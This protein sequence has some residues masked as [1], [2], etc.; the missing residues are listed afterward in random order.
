MVLAVILS[1]VSVG[2]IV[3]RAAGG[4]PLYLAAVL[5]LALL[6][7]VLV[8][9]RWRLLARSLDLIVPVGVAVRAQFVAMFG[10]QVLPSA[11]G[12]DVLRGWAVT[13]HAGDVSRVVASL[14]ADRLVALFAACLLALPSLG[15]LVGP[16]VLAGWVG[17][18]WVARLLGP[19]A[20]LAAGGA[21][22]A[23][24][25][26]LRRLEGVAPRSRPIGL[27]IG[28][29]LGTHATAVMMAVLAAAAYR[30]DSSLILWFSVI[31][32]SIIVSAI[33]V[34][35]N[36]WGVR[37][38]AIVVLAGPLGVPAPEALLVSMTLGVL[39]M[40][41]SLPGAVVLLR[42]RGRGVA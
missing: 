33:P 29:A 35:L 38:G 34:S 17:P 37:E 41:A 30:V 10:G 27:A 12:I 16:P 7:F 26:G 19:A 28:M 15:G 5:A 23:F 11:I 2:D 24:T 32:V 22:L 21:L 42:G 1:R 8:A 13:P 39:S 3:A 36:G 6:S 4:N 31:P 25:V 40:L 20:V 18:S 14:M 9:L